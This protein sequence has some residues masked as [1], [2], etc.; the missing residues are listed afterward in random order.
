MFLEEFL[1]VPDARF[2]FSTFFDF[3]Y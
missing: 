3:S 2:T 1:P